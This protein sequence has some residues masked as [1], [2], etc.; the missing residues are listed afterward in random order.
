MWR[1]IDQFEALEMN[2]HDRTSGVFNRCSEADK[3]RFNLSPI[4]I[5]SCR[6]RE[7]L[8]ERYA[9]LFPHDTLFSRLLLRQP[10]TPW[11]QDILCS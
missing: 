8:V 6:M 1:V 11:W 5:S 2:P 4:E 3:E 9:M 7:N 10:P